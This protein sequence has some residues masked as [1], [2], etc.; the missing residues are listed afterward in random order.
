MKMLCFWILATLLVLEP[1]LSHDHFSFPSAPRT[2]SYRSEYEVEDQQPSSK[3]LHKI[4]KLRKKQMLLCL[5]GGGGGGGGGRN[6]P[7]DAPEP[8]FLFPVIQQTEVNVGNPSGGNNHLSSPYGSGMCDGLLGSGGGGLGGLGHPGLLS[9]PLLASLGS[10]GSG[11]G[12]NKPDTDEDQNRYLMHFNM[13]RHV[14][15]PLYKSM[16]AFYKLFR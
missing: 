5:L 16:K 2:V 11:S 1:V 4:K 15:R 3:T 8:R 12:T 14:V 9:H 7:L 6:S 10:L 13:K